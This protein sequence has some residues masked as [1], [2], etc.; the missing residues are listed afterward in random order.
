M[1]GTVVGV[2]KIAEFFFSKYYDVNFSQ[3]W[4]QD[5]VDLLKS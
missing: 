4:Q 5:I 1:V 2:V 3:S